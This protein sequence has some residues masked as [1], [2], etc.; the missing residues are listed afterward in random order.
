MH[1]AFFELFPLLGFVDD[2]IYRTPPVDHLSGE[3][4]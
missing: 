2:P 3:D 1:D 4:V